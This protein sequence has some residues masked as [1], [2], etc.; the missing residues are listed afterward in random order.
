MSKSLRVWIGAVVCLCLFGCADVGEETLA[1]Q[2]SVDERGQ[3]I[4]SPDS[5]EVAP[6]SGS[7]LD[8]TG[9]SDFDDRQ[10]SLGYPGSIV[11]NLETQR[12]CLERG[13]F[14]PDFEPPTSDPVGGGVDALAR[15]GEDGYLLFSVDVGSLRIASEQEWGRTF[16]GNIMP[17]NPKAQAIPLD[18]FQLDLVAAGG[19]D[20]LMQLGAELVLVYEVP[21]YN[22]LPSPTYLYVRTD[23]ETIGAPLTYCNVLA[24]YEEEAN[25]FL[26]QANLSDTATPEDLW[27]SVFFPAHNPG[28]IEAFRTWT[29]DPNGA[30]WSG[31]DPLDR[32]LDNAPAATRSRYVPEFVIITIPDDWKGTSQSDG[33][34]CTSSN[35]G[36]HTCS[37]MDITEDLEKLG[38]VV[39]QAWV[40]VEPGQD[41]LRVWLKS[42][43]AV[44]ATRIE[45]GALPMSSFKEGVPRLVVNTDGSVSPGELL[46][47]AKRDELVIE[48][49]VTI[50]AS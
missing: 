46:T 49:T 24:D 11:A 44:N 21:E 16:T 8:F 40:P 42:D 34:I 12:L 30:T 2:P 22:L 45:L 39:L 36:W 4:E 7:P 23:S 28:L 32:V 20:M 25:R 47:T 31:L 38:G 17:L 41:T 15:I 29:V 3:D 26:A 43:S 9:Q 10:R 48:S 19:L 5:G 27:T 50:A 6:T 14:T 1:G 18:S 13:A 37:A 33:V 35:E